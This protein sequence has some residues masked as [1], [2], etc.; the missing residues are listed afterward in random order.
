MTVKK[1]SETHGTLHEANVGPYFFAFDFFFGEFEIFMMKSYKIFWTY[2]SASKM[3]E[4]F[5]SS[6]LK[7]RNLFKIGKKS[8]EYVFNFKHEFKNS[9]LLAKYWP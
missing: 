8:S 9:I 3:H 1:G 5:T 2:Y 6:E 7:E 4:C